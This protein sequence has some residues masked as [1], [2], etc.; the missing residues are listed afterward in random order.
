MR[1]PDSLRES[2]SEEFVPGTK[3]AEEAR[4]AQIIAA[5]YK[6]AAQRGLQAITVRDVARKAGVSVGLVIF[7]FR[8]KDR[9][10][11]ALL[12]WVI[13]NTVSLSVD[14]ETAAIPDPLERLI[15]ILQ[16]EMK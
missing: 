16:S 11:L 4:R 15:A 3:A 1:R 2:P 8:T 6:V 5:A 10:V 12:D 14:A 13:A 7:H 9:V